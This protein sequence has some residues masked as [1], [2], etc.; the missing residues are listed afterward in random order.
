MAQTHSTRASAIA[1]PEPQP[2]SATASRGRIIAI[3]IGVILGMLLAGLDQTVVGTALPRIVASLGGLEHY[4]WV[5]TAY[6]LASTVSIP[7]YGKLSD[8]Y[9]RRLFFIGGMVIFLAGSALAGTSQD[10]TQLIIYRAIQGLGAG[11]LMPIAQ[12]VIGDIFPPAERGKWQGLIF[13]VFGL[14]TIIGPTLGGWITDNWGWRWVFYVNMP[15]GAIAILTAGFVMPKL[16]NR[17][18]HIIDYLGVVTLIAGTVPLLLA[19]SWAGTQYAWGSWQIIGLFIFSAVMLVIFVL[20]EMRT[21][22]PIITPQLFKNSI[23]LISVMAMFLV[24]AG[25][26]VAILYLPLFAQGVLGESA[27]NSGVILTPMMV[28]F[29]FS[30]IVGGQLLSRTGRYK[31]LAII[32][33]AVA[34]VDMF[35]LSRMAATTTQGE[36]IRNMIITGLGAG[37]LLSLFTI[38]VQNAFPYRQLGEVTAS[39]NFFRSIGSTIGVAVMGTILT[40]AFQSNLQRNMPQALTRLASAK[41]LPLAQLQNPQLLLTPDVVAKIQRGFAVFG[42]QGLALFHQLIEAIRVSLSSAITNVFFLGFLIMLL[43]LFSVLF[44]REI[45]LRKSDIAQPAEVTPSGSDQQS[46]QAID[47]VVN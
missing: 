2:L 45:P 8:I 21:A 42:A 40:N 6:L 35:L 5:V 12:A 14:T 16:V 13:A 1:I 11:A 32:G 38:V 44:L 18:Q 37:V 3:L 47:Q 9:G 43:G 22:E 25:V 23:F 4:A 46:D 26:F 15:L 34:A 10:M 41:H 31:I 20:V 33:F 7:L 24:S 30:S 27:T 39:L 36:V 19:F 28:G 17:R 29:I